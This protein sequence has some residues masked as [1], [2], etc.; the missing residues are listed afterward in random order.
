[1]VLTLPWQYNTSQPLHNHRL[2][3][4]SPAIGVEINL[5]NSIIFMGYPKKDPFPFP[6]PDLPGRKDF[7]VFN[8]PAST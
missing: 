1:M 5:I 7:K 3:R 4:P 8:P 6:I 2:Q